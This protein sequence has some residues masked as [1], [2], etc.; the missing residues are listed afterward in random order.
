MRTLF[1]VLPRISGFRAI[2]EFFL[3][4]LAVPGTAFPLTPCKLFN[5]AKEDYAVLSDK[6]V[7]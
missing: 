2:Y 6:S 4:T 5:D 1:A 7:V 3:Q